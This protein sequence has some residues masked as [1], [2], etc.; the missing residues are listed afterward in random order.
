MYTIP[1]SLWIQKTAYL[2]PYPLIVALVVLLKLS[3]FYA[4]CEAVKLA[5]VGTSGQE[6]CFH[7]L[8]C[9]CALDKQL[10]MNNN[11]KLHGFGHNTSLFCLDH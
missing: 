8:F 7:L 10:C 3:Q 2:L 11:I 4:R 6:F 5:V 9:P 1:V